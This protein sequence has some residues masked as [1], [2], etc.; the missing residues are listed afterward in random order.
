MIEPRIQQESK[1]DKST[2]NLLFLI[3][4]YRLGYGLDMFYVGP[5]QTPLSASLQPTRPHPM[6]AV[7]FFLGSKTTGA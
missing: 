3:S 5:K 7:G 6:A 2:Q 1:A 4:E